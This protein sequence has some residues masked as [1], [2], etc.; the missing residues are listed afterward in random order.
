MFNALC[1]NAKAQAANFPFCTI[2]P[3]VGIVA[4]PDPR[5]QELRWAGARGLHLNVCRRRQAIAVLWINA[6]AGCGWVAALPQS[7]GRSVEAAA[8]A[9]PP[10]FRRL[11]PAADPPAA[12][13]QAARRSSPPAWSLW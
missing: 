3:N 13:F 4:V 9:W 10:W 1:E 5:L 8:E 7:R 12:R 6:A 11:P 2:E